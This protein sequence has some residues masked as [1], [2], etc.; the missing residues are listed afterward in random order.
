MEELLRG[1]YFDKKEVK[2]K[3][4]GLNILRGYKLTLVTLKTGLHLQIDVCSRVYRSNNLLEE[5][6][7]KKSKDF[8][9]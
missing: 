7:N 6:T 2:L 5:L 8:A 9:D 3:E 4:T 1:K